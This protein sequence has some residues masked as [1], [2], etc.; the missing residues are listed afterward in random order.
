VP[1]I[2]PATTPASKLSIE[3]SAAIAAAGPSRVPASST[4]VQVERQPVF[5]HD[6]AGDGADGSNI[7][8]QEPGHSRHQRNAHQRCRH[9]FDAWQAR[10]ANHDCTDDQGADHSL[11]ADIRHRLAEIV[12][13]FDGGALG[14]FGF[15]PQG[16]V[17]LS[18]END[19]GNAT[20]ESGDDRHRNEVH[21]P[22]KAKDTERQNHEPGHDA[23]NPDPLQAML[24]PDQNEHRRHR[25]G[26]PADLI[27]RAAQRADDD[28]GDDGG[29]QPG[30]CRRS[31]GNAEGQCQRQRDS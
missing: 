20:G 30:G 17:D 27:G 4:V 19:E 2:R 16:V 13:Q 9:S 28:A 7:P 18:D 29:H 25:T 5:Q 1:V 12:E 26:R 21:D 22:A 10:Q 23:G 3:P 11:V 8:A 24:L 6:R 15:Y 14:G 31:T